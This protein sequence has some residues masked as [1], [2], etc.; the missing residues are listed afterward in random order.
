MKKITFTHKPT[1]QTDA[2]HQ[3]AHCVNLIKEELGFEDDDKYGYVYW[4]A[5]CKGK[6]LEDVQLTLE[7]M[8]EVEKWLKGKGEVLN[9]G[10]W[11]S[12]NI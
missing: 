4:L 8:K 10:G 3:P 7:K 2:P 12:N 5:R 6:K 9:R 11:L 1:I